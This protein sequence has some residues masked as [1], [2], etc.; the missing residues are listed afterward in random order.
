MCTAVDEHANQ[1]HSSAL[2][3]SIYSDREPDNKRFAVVPVRRT[4]WIHEERES[5]SPRKVQMGGDREWRPMERK[6][7]S[8][9]VQKNNDEK[10]QQI[11]CIFDPG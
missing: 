11:G 1:M 10:S 4:C 6:S 8:I 2:F 7:R 3:V 5:V 9:N